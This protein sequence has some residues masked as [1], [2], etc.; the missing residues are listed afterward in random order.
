MV[1]VHQLVVLHKLSFSFSVVVLVNSKKLT[2]MIIVY[3]SNSEFSTKYVIGGM[4]QIMLGKY[5]K[6][7]FTDILGNKSKPKVHQ[8]SFFCRDGQGAADNVAFSIL[9]GVSHQGSPSIFDYA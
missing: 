8:S 1:S 7:F 5:I 6:H 9:H 2:T 3:L 4:C